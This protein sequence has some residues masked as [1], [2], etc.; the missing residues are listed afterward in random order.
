[1][2]VGRGARVERI[3]TRVISLSYKAVI[4]A[5]IFTLILLLITNSKFLFSIYTSDYCARYTAIQEKKSKASFVH[6]Y[7][8]QLVL[9]CFFSHVGLKSMMKL[10]I[11]RGFWLNY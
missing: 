7:Y 1:M 5:S 9:L 8:S 10:E 3:S 6:T 11:Q 4:I 2:S